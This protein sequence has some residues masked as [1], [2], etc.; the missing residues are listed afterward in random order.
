MLNLNLV[1]KLHE[2]AMFNIQSMV[3]FAKFK[4]N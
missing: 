2:N 1:M 3:D 4:I